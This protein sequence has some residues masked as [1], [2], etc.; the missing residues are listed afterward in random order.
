MIRKCKQWLTRTCHSST[1]FISVSERNYTDHIHVIKHVTIHSVTHV[2]FCQAL[3]LNT[4]TVKC[5]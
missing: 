2:H 5:E 1:L 4:A 3:M